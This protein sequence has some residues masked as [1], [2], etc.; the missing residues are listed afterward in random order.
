M[1]RG[2][3]WC[4]LGCGPYMGTGDLGLRR[5]LIAALFGAVALTVAGCGESQVGPEGL[6]ETAAE[7]LPVGSPP[8]EV[9]PASDPVETAASDEGAATL[10][11]SAEGAT[12][13]IPV[14]VVE[15]VGVSGGPG[16]YSF[17]VTIRSPESGCDQYA[18]WWEVIS[19]DGELLYRR[20]LLHPHVSEQP[21]TRSGGPVRAEPAT[22]LIV[23]GHMSTGG[24][25]PAMR[26]SVATGFAP[27]DLPADF[28][29]SVELAPPLPD[30]CA[31]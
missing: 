21:F 7:A 16:S 22:E 31:R 6:S 9:A 14:A 10:T 12:A 5:F 1:E 17:N 3:S 15:A 11:V 27:A 19:V 4:L 20:V 30:G 25:G 28:A 8:S 26:G 24:Y 18:D 2:F 23:R 13:V 29:L